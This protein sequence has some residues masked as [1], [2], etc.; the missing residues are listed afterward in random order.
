MKNS[1]KIFSRRKFIGQNLKLG[2]L[3]TLS[4][5]KLGL[6]QENK[7]AS[8]VVELES[9]AYKKLFTLKNNFTYFNTGSLGPSP[10]SVTYA[11]IDRLKS[12][13]VNASNGHK[14]F[15]I[16]REKLAKLLHTKTSLIG[17]TRNATEGMNIVARS[18][19][20]KPSDEVILTTHEHIGGAAPW[21]ALQKEIGITIKLVELDLSGKKNY[22]LIK[23]QITDKTKV[24]VF[25]HVLC[26]TGMILPA[27]K[28]S[29]LCRKREIYSVV[30]GA[31]AAGLIDIDIAKIK[32]HFYIGSGHKWLF[33]PKGTGFIYMDEAF[34]TE[35]PPHFVGAYS[36]CNF[37]L[38]NLELDYLQTASREEYGTRNS[39]ITEGFSTALDFYFDIEI[40]TI[41]AHY[42]KLRTAFEKEI[43]DYSK[44]QIL[45]PSDRKCSTGLYT[46]R[47]KNQ[48]NIELS[49]T[50]RKNLIV[51]RGIYE[52]DL[53]AIRFSFAIFNTEEDAFNAAREV[54]K[55]I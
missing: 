2:L 13:E 14:I 12:N 5:T 1:K 21:L 54:I 33:G 8:H 43:R 7:L 17:I 31:Q 9:S 32:P 41:T 16:C 26:T 52:N 35:N 11:V 4:F 22:D 24:I 53:N 27:G 44:I 20:L 45:S 15:D 25:S 36:D 28:I 6:A 55:L 18:L 39:A 29:A 49:K 10:R 47:V 40:D 34:L 48:D 37:D 46:I 38:G 50:L 30:D 19:K 23:N 3:S 42:E 51:T